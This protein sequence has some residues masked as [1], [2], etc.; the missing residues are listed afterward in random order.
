[1]IGPEIKKSCFKCEACTS[2]SYS[3]QGD[4][5]H[6]VYCAHKDHEEQKYIGDTTWKTPDWCP[7]LIPSS[8]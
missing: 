1:M 5:G 4:S 3:V 2:K 8:Q 7:A 6:T